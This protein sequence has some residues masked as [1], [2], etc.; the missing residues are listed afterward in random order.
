MTVEGD[1]LGSDLRALLNFDPEAVPATDPV[2]QV[3]VGRVLADFSARVRLR[4]IGETGWGMT[5]NRT[6]ATRGTQQVLF[7]QR[8][9]TMCAIPHR[10]RWSSFR[11][12]RPCR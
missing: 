5:P 2:V 12:L 7:V 11:K 1:K 9:S 3:R 10:H 4:P 8:P 6:L